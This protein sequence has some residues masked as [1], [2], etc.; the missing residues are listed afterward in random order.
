MIRI[1]F[2]DDIEE[3]DRTEILN[4]IVK[5]KFLSK[6][7]YEEPVLHKPELY[8]PE[9]YTPEYDASN[10]KETRQDYD[11]RVKNDGICEENTNTKKLTFLTTKCISGTKRS[12]DQ[13]T[14][15][16]KYGRGSNVKKR[17][18]GQ[19]DEVHIRHIQIK[20]RYNVK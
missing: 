19:F 8:T 16:H 11:T 5:K 14:L 9:L 3:E 13:I 15:P 12:I 18:V 10:K 4:T 2:K 6:T 20:E 17:C 7:V 1:S